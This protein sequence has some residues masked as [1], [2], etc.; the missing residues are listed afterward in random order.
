MNSTRTRARELDPQTQLGPVLA[1]LPARTG[2]RAWQLGWTHPPGQARAAALADPAPLYRCTVWDGLA[3]GLVAAIGAGAVRQI[4]ILTT[5]TFGVRLFVPA[6]IFGGFA[7][8]V[9][10]VAMWRNQLLE[11]GT[12]TVRGWAAGSGLGFGLAA[13][14]IIALPHASGPFPLAPDQMSSAAVAVLAVWIGLAVLIFMPFP[15]W[16]GHWADA[17]QQRAGLAAPRVPARGGMVVAAVAAWAVMAT[18]LYLLMLSDVGILVGSSAVTVWHQLPQSIRGMGLDLTAQGG[19][20]LGGWVVCLVIV[21]VPLAAAV[22]HRH[23]RRSGD[24]PG[25]AVPGR[26][27]VATALLCGRWGPGS[28]RADAGAQRRHARADRRTGAVEP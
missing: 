20:Q 17:W 9:L 4:V 8:A 26:R 22:V 14:W 23:W 28:G 25:A 3:V 24:A 11:A 6:V 2:R 10:V 12:G 5:T 16:V 7:G 1:A 18:G 15:V 13:G 21:A 27:A 19:D